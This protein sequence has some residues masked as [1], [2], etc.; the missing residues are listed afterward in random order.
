MR[1][2]SKNH[3]YLTIIGLICQWFISCNSDQDT[4]IDPAKCKECSERYYLD[5]I[6][7]EDY[8]YHKSDYGN[9]LI[10]A[11]K[12]QANTLY[13][14]CQDYLP[15]S[16]ETYDIINLKGKIFSACD[17]TGTQ[18]MLLPN[19]KID[20]YEITGKSYVECTKWN[21]S[22]YH[23]PQFNCVVDTFISNHYTEEALKLGA[24]YYKDS[25]NF[26]Y[27]D[28]IVH[29]FLQAYTALFYSGL[30]EVEDII[31]ISSRYDLN[32]PIGIVL[33]YDTV[34]W[35]TNIS[36]NKPSG[37]T[38]F[39]SL[40]NTFHLKIETDPYNGTIELAPTDIVINSDSLA[41][42]FTKID[43]IY[44]YPYDFEFGS[45]NYTYFHIYPDGLFLRFT[46]GWGDCPAGCL[47]N[48]S[49]EFMV[50]EDCSVEF[51]GNCGTLRPTL[52]ETHGN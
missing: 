27:D 47:Y 43:S 18:H 37:N 31:N 21:D 4:N 36:Q 29:T 20:E 26:L 52:E 48:K 17:S 39:D 25:I 24:I 35:A 19:L 14:V 51:L 50:Y 5:D 33:E 22:N 28:T 9:F 23:I 46:I 49:W 38:V 44:S 8:V 34:H 7:L 12:P 30:P 11:G 1:Y 32:R 10:Y 16:L 3:I 2:F 40:I 15:D 45:G 13:Y 42:Y 41:T 6:T